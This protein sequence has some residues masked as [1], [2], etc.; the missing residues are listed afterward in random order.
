MSQLSIDEQQT[1]P[2]GTPLQ[3]PP[4]V[5]SQGSRRAAS[6]AGT[7]VA[8]ES[9]RRAS[10]NGVHLNSSSPAST[11][12]GPSKMS[13]DV[14]TL[15][16]QVASLQAEL[17]ASNGRLQMWEDCMRQLANS[18]L[19]S[20]EMTDMYK[21]TCVELIHEALSSVESV[22]RAAQATR[23]PRTRARTRTHARASA[24]TRPRTRP[25]ARAPPSGPARRV[26]GL[27]LPVGRG[28]GAAARPAPVDLD[29]LLRVERLLEAVMDR[30]GDL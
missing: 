1:P 7:A 25:R 17:A 22:Q 10:L 20:P 12:G 6:P 11:P 16:R 2:K 27:L 21:T 4:P 23:A 29:G 3:S 8:E 13:S 26:C 9:P 18:V 14:A 28:G 24:R 30:A 5:S 15:Q 19:L